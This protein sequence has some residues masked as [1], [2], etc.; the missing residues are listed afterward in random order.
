[1]LRKRASSTSKSCHATTNQQE[2]MDQFRIVSSVFESIWKGGE[3][4]EGGGA[5]P[6]NQLLVDRW[7]ANP[8]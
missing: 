4:R 1:M 5:E 6:E 3:K 8:T 2:C 7:P